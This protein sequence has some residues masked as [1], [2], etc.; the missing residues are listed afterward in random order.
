[1]RRGE[2]WT[3][4]E[5]GA[6]SGKPR[7]VVIVQADM[8]DDVGSV[9]VVLFTTEKHGG[10]LPRLPVAPDSDN[11]LRS[12]SQLMV[13]KITTT[14]RTSLGKRLGSLSDEDMRRLETA[15]M[16]FLGLAK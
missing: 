9:T 4:A 8:F 6:Y 16:A 11:G 7:P 12:E 1:M 10:F 13:D 14:Q 2:I 15:I 5:R 3:A